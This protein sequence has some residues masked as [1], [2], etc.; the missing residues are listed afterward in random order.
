MFVEYLFE[1]GIFLALKMMNF[2][3]GK[4]GNDQTD[5]DFINNHRIDRL[6]PAP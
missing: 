6:F 5:C 1:Q 4:T 3:P 2:Y